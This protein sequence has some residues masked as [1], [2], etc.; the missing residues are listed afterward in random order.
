MPADVRFPE[1]GGNLPV[2]VICHSFMA[3]KDWGFF[4]YAAEELA[5][6]GMVTV[7]FNFSHNGVA[8]N[9]NR[10]TDFGRFERN[11]F[12]RE[13]DDLGALLDGLRS[14]GTLPSVADPDMIALLGHS[15]GGGLAIVR[16]ADDARVSA[17]VSW[18][19]IATFDRWTPHQKAA[20]RSAGHL[21]LARNTTVSP[22]RLGLDLLR[23]V[24][25][26]RGALD[27]VRAGSRLGKP[28]LILHGREDRTVQVRESEALYAA[29]DKAAT[30]LI[31]LDHVGH[32]YNA[33][34]RAEDGYRTLDRVIDATSQWLLRTL[35]TR[36]THATDSRS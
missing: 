34:T 17:V 12:S 21:P 16:G 3:F 32:L 25:E 24:E 29:A 28:W 7:A 35:H 31:V 1:H 20:W 30:D 4:P 2:V 15:R 26:N 19:A 23:D 9:G 33:A 22:L 11:T 8:G 27:I 6:A 5:R 18:S 36:R 10:I 13:L 14:A